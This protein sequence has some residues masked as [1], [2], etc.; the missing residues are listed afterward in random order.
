LPKLRVAATAGGASIDVAGIFE[1]EPMCMHTT[2][3]V[4]WHATKK[5]SQYPVWMLGNPRCGGSR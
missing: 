3:E 1:L 5:G 2:V 4:S